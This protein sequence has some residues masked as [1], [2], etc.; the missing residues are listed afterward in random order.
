MKHKASPYLEVVDE[1][2]Q[3][4]GE[5]APRSTVFGVIGRTKETGKMKTLGGLVEHAPTER[6]PKGT[7]EHHPKMLGTERHIT[8]PASKTHISGHH[9]GMTPYPGAYFAH[10]GHRL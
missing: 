10:L 6:V 1:P 5:G 4:R 9:Y 7:V 3:M 2:R 8:G